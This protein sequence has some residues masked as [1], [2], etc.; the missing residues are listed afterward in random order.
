MCAAVRCRGDGLGEFVSATLVDTEYGK[1]PCTRG[2]DRKCDSSACPTAAGE[3][4]GLVRRVM[5]FPLHSDHATEAVEDGTDPVSIVMATHDVEGAG[6]TS[7]RR[8]LC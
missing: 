4:N 2:R 6:L 5:T 8:Q 7:S 3:K 1:C